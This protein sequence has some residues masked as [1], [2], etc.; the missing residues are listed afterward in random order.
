MTFAE[1]FLSTPGRIEVAGRQIKRY[2][3][4]MTDSELDQA[5]QDAAYALVPQLL[6][7]PDETPPG[8]FSVLHRSAMGAY[9]LVYSWIGMDVLNLHAAVA[10][11]PVLGAPDEDPT[12][13]AV[14]T[15][16]WIGCVWEL[17]PLEHER[18]AWVRHVLQPDAPDLAGYLADQHAPGPVGRPTVITEILG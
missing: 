18:S 17:A 4:T 15:R 7:E 5:I 6:P 14:S 11:V 3:I 9:L 10:G 13:F 1:R 12:H 8:S 16:H 2:H